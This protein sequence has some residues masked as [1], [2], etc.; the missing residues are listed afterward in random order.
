MTG[1]SEGGVK[2]ADAYEVEVG[3]ARDTGRPVPPECACRRRCVAPNS[4]CV[5]LPDNDRFHG[6]SNSSLNTS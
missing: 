5:C 4:Q 2:V 1:E 3:S 6:R